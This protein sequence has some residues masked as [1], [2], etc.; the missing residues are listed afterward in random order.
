MSTLG[1][2]LEENLNASFSKTSSPCFADGSA[3]VLS[4]NSTVLEYYNIYF[5]LIPSYPAT[6][7]TQLRV[8][9]LFEKFLLFTGFLG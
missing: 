9:L 6:I 7:Y 3:G 5:V 4:L 2:E 8:K 1:L